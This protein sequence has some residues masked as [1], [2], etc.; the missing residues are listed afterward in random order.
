RAPR[1]RGRR[2]IGQHALKLHLVREQILGSKR[3]VGLGEILDEPPEFLVAQAGRQ[4]V[5]GGGKAGREARECNE[6]NG[7]RREAEASRHPDRPDCSL[8]A[9]PSETRSAADARRRA[10]PTAAGAPPTRPR[11]AWRAASL[12]R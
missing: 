7:H 2:E 4:R 8:T 12:R 6:G 9:T 5:G 1:L 3:A 10:A 11:S